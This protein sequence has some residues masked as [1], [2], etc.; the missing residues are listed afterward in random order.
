MIGTRGAGRNNEDGGRAY[1]R[2]GRVRR[3]ALKIRLFGAGR[4]LVS[5]RRRY[6]H[7]RARARRDLLPCES[8][9]AA[10]WRESVGL[11]FDL[12]RPEVTVCCGG[13]GLEELF[14]AID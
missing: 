9:R 3:N 14:F 13:P 2:G 1:P 4:V 6:D 11:R 5:P 10:L 8:G 12:M 7:W